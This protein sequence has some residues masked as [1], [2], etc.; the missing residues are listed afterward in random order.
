MTLWIVIQPFFGYFMRAEAPVI[1]Q[2][3]RMCEDL[4]LDCYK[5]K[6]CS[7]TTPCTVFVMQMEGTKCPF[8]N[9]SQETKK[10]FT[11]TVKLIRK[12]ERQ[13]ESIVDI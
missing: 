3:A 9:C 4:G 1:L 13:Q 12:A 8:D 6:L 2:E 7:Q 5:F 11:A 10:A